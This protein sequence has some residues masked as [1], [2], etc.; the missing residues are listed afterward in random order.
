MLL[1]LFDKHFI[2]SWYMTI[3]VSR[4]KWNC[5]KCQRTLKSVFV[6]QCVSFL[7][8][9][10]MSYKHPEVCSTHSLSR[11]PLRRPI[12][13]KEH[14]DFVKNGSLLSWFKPPDTIF[15]ES[16]SSTKRLPQKRRTIFPDNTWSLIGKENLYFYFKPF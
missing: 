13:T 8:I 14:S 4:C 12:N 10:R 11:L 3:I 1:T 2:L 9:N 6:F 15:R 7:N 5:K 16:T